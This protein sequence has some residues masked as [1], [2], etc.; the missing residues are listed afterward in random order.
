RLDRSRLYHTAEVIPS[1]DLRR[2]R[3]VFVVIPRGGEA[4][5]GDDIDD[6]MDSLAVDARDTDSAMVASNANTGAAEGAP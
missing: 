4:P 1:A 3:Y 5:Q 2:M 6:V